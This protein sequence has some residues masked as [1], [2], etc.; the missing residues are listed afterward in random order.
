MQQIRRGDSAVRTKALANGP[1]GIEFFSFLS[2]KTYQPG[3]AWRC[4]AINRYGH[5]FLFFL[6][7]TRCGELGNSIFSGPNVPESVNKCCSPHSAKTAAFSEPSGI[8]K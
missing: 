2:H 1:V 5:V 6:F 4:D 7:P 3:K 8:A